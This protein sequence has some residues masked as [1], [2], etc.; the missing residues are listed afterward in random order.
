MFDAKMLEKEAMPF[1]RVSTTVLYPPVL[2]KNGRVLPGDHYGNS[3]LMRPYSG[4]LTPDSD[5]KYGN[6]EINII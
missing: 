3:M 5:S 4:S 1:G 2:A 6:S